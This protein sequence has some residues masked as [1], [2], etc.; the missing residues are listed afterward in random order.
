M[1]SYAPDY[2]LSDP[3]GSLDP[4]LVGAFAAALQLHEGRYLVLPKVVKVKQP[5]AGADFTQAVPGGVV[6]ILLSVRALLTTSVVVANRF[7]RLRFTDGSD[8]YAESGAGGAIAASLAVNCSWSR[9]FGSQSFVAAS[10][11]NNSALPNMPLAQNH[12]IVCS[13]ALIDV[14][15]QWTNVVYYVLEVRERTPNERAD[16]IESLMGG[17][18]TTD[19]PGLLLGL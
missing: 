5:A 9:E 10:G 8:T 16:Y 3:P 4:Q 11:V 2:G 1:S 7:P 12:V 17:Q 15:D 18:P 13:T 6:W 19:Y 14:G